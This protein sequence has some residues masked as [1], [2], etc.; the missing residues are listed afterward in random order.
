MPGDCHKTWYNSPV[1]GR[2][3][4]AEGSAS[5]RHANVSPEDERMQFVCDGP[6][7]TWFRFETEGEATQESRLMEHSVE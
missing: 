6:N 7:G 4:F 2:G 1:R 5:L 3:C